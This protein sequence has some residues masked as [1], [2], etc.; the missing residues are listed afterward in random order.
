MHASP[1]VPARTTSS[2]RMSGYRRR[3]L[4]APRVRG[5]VLG[6]ILPQRCQAAPSNLLQRPRADV[7]VRYHAHL[8][9]AWPARH[10]LGIQT[11]DVQEDRPV[12]AVVRLRVR[13]GA[14]GDAWLGSHCEDGGERLGV[15]HEPEVPPGLD[16]ETGEAE[17]LAPPDGVAR[18]GLGGDPGELRLGRRVRREDAGEERQAAATTEQPGD[19]L[20]LLPPV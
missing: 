11:V 2:K 13:A 12:P 20:T 3:G 8:V 18:A 5:V 4:V 10:E 6:I 19:Q 9:L 7:P 15:G 16:E 17:I 1:A 14:V